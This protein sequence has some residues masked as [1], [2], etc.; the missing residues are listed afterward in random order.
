MISIKYYLSLII[1]GKRLI[2]N[3][4]NYVYVDGIWIECGWDVDGMFF[5]NFFV[6]GMLMECGW[7]V[8]GM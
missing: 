7:D 5:F 8:N 3:R 2:N 1:P 6:D 4:F